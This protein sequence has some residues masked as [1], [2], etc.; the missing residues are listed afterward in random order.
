MG[1]ATNDGRPFLLAADSCLQQRPSVHCVAIAFAIAI[2]LKKHWLK[3]ICP[4]D[5]LY[6]T[7]VNPTGDTNQKQAIIPDASLVG[8]QAITLHATRSRIQWNY[9]FQDFLCWV[10]ELAGT[11]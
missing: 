11:K 7:T 6:P 10:C 3:C 9:S 1:S 2:T 5:K 4:D 8:S